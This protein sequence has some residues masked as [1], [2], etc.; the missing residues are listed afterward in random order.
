MRVLHARQE[1]TVDTYYKNDLVYRIERALAEAEMRERL[2]R[3]P[4]VPSGRFDFRIEMLEQ[5]RKTDWYS[6]RV[7]ENRG[8]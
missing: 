5:A 1:V 6:F 4:C 7:F 3:I 2:S 8:K